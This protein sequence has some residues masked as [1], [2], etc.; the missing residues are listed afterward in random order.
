MLDPSSH[1]I[2][3]HPKEASLKSQKNE[4]KQISTHLEL[5]AILDIVDPRSWDVSEAPEET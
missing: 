1:S 5:L 4:L 2:Q 3:L